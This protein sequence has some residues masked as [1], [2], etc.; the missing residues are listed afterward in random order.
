MNCFTVSVGEPAAKL[1]VFLRDNAYEFVDHS[2]R[3]CVLICPGGGYEF[4]SDREGEPIAAAFIQ[5]GYQTCVL[6]YAVRPGKTGAFL[7]DIPLNQAAA[8]LRTIRENAEEWGIDPNKVTVLG[9]SAGGHLAGSLG[10]FGSDPG[11]ISGAEN[12]LSQPNAMI[13]CYPVI[14]A[15]EH[16]HEDSI[17]NLSGLPMGD[18]GREAYS[19]EKNVSSTTCPAFIWQT[20]VDDCVPVENAMLMAS[21][22]QRRHIP[23]ELHLYTEGCHGLSTADHCAGQGN[24]IDDHVATWTK[25]AMQWLNRMGVGPGY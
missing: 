3:P 6:H 17:F 11:R 18:P 19:L 12:G 13:L 24:L 23:Y 1:D 16:C 14:T 7:G 21:A 5:A 10:V 25:L 20:T 22:M 9:C 8:A 2:H 4:V 15:G